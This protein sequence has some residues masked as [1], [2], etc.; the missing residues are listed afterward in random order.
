MKKLFYCLIICLVQSYIGHTQVISGNCYIKGQYVEVGINQCG[1]W[2]TTNN[3]PAGYHPRSGTQLLNPGDNQFNLGFVADPD[4]NGW[5]IGVPHYY[6]DYFMP[7]SP[8]V[9]WGISFNGLTFGSERTG[10]SSSACAQLFSGSII[11]PQVGATVINTPQ[12]MQATWQGFASNMLVKKIVTVKPLELYFTVRIVLRNTSLTPINNIYYGEYVNPDNDAYINDVFSNNLF[13]TNTIASQ[14]PTGPAQVVALGA[15]TN[16]YISLG[17]RDCR[18]KVFRSTPNYVPLGSPIDWYLNTPAASIAQTG[19]DFA[20][21]NLSIGIAFNVGTIAPGDSTSFLYTYIL[22]S[23]DFLPAL[24][25]TDPNF[26]INGLDYPSGDTI[27]PCANTI[28]PMSVLNGD[29]NTWTWSPNTRLNTVFGV[30][31]IANVG[32]TPITYT[33]T[34]VG[35]CGIKTIKITIDPWLKPALGPDQTDFI[36]PGSLANLW[37]VFDTTGVSSAWTR[38]GFVV[39][40][41]AAVDTGTYRLIGTNPGGCKDTAFVVVQYFNKPQLGIDQAG[42]ICP[43]NSYDLSTAFL[44]TGLTSNWT[45]AGIAVANPT[46]VTIP[47]TYE[48]IATSI[49]GCSDTAVLILG[50]GTKPNLG[51]DINLQTCPGTNIDLTTQYNTAGLSS[52]WTSG[53]IPVPNPSSVA[54]GIYQIIV[55][56][57]DGC[58]DTA[59]V[60]VGLYPKPP[61]GADKAVGICPGSFED[62]TLEYNTTGLSSFWTN[63]GIAVPNPNAVDIGIYQLIAINSNGCADTAI[64][65]VSYNP[66]PNLGAD[67][68]KGICPGTTEDLTLEFTTTGMT[69]NWS[70]GGI[71]VANPNSVGIG[72]YQLIASNGTGCSDTAMVTVNYNPVPILGADKNLFTCPGTNV[73]LTTQFITTGLI[74]NWTSGGIPVSNP[75]SVGAG[76]YQLIAINTFGCSDTALATVGLYPKPNLGADKLKGIC[77]GSSEDLTTEYITTGLTTNW[78]SAGMPVPNPSAVGVGIYQLIAINATGCADTAIVAVNNNPKPNLGADKT[79]G[80]CPATTEDLT[81]EYITTGL[82]SNWTIGGVPVPNP[83]AV[84]IGVYQLIASNGS[85]CADTAIV[86]VNQNPAPALGADKNIQTCPGTSVDLT[87]QFIT[88]GLTTNWTSAGVPVPNPASAGAGLYQLIAINAFGCADTA[89]VNVSLFPKPTLGADISKN[90]CLGSFEDL[91]LEFTT[92]GLTSNWTSAGIPVPNPTAVIAG[93]YQLIATNANGCSDTAI[94]TIGNFPKPNL[95]AD[96]N[97]SVCPGNTVNLTTQYNTTGLTSNWTSAGVPVANPLAVSAGI[98]QLIVS[99]SNSCADTAFVLVSLY[100]KPNL[101]ADKNISTCPGTT[102]NLTTLFATG[103]WT[104]TW[105][106]PTPTAVGAGYY[107]LIVTNS[108]GCTDTAHVTVS[109]YPKPDLG[110]D[111]TVSICPNETIDLNTLF[112]TSGLLVAWS[113]ANPQSAGTGFYT[114]IAT[115][116]NGC[117][118]TANVTVLLYPAINPT[119]ALSPTTTT[120]IEGTA[121]RFFA[122][123][124]NIVSYLWEP[125]VSLSTVYGASV[126]ATPATTTRYKLT[127]K[128]NGGCEDSAFVTLTVIPLEIEPSAAFTP[129]GDGYTDKWVVKNIQLSK[130]NKVIIYNRWGNKVFEANNYQNN[131]DGTFKGNPLPDGAYYYQI[132]ATTIGKRTIHKAGSITLLR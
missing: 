26:R 55:T 53:G 112:N 37:T 89:L 97:L 122:G 92:T 16:S 48:L 64:V 104:T 17:S 76:I 24:T 87:T 58:T 42:L 116:S 61:L 123:G 106:S 91:T 23:T 130:T 41:P 85:G 66:K 7:V 127:V 47:G 115:N 129:N 118:D 107:T 74:S 29:Y 57:G 88:T 59:M 102:V 11:M 5:N 73:D 121:I 111:Q 8:Y 4:R 71:P 93:I 78:T 45:L 113:I 125:G 70:S 119:I 86:A 83:S 95:G 67:K 80:I 19:F 39:A 20:P 15:A 40:N 99:N 14:T 52:D 75:S 96:I 81:T 103:V 35:P 43:G 32:T 128:N 27:R 21:T 18:A 126:V 63:G 56:N 114:I 34:G 124:T 30:N 36:C 38:N 120:I 31:V 72:I 68:V 90:I 28:L 54:D 3:A 13:T 44:T 1:G 108:N 79:K 6:G 82:I 100:P 51:A 77:P 84:G 50:V 49:N 9:G 132:E 98:Y 46:A 2:G 33:A 94:V 101:G 22:K 117:M 10:T 110:P 131:W 105:D 109:L 62:L 25:E 69:T 12:Y 65:T 60:T